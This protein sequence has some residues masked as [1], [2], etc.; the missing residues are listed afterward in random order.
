MYAAEQLSFGH[1]SLCLKLVVRLRAQEGQEF[2]TGRSSLCNFL[3]LSLS[4]VSSKY[5][6]LLTMPTFATSLDREAC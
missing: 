6:R 5:T 2:G 3:A 1:S 4:P